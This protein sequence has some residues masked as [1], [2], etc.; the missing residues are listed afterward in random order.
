M[1]SV[2]ISDKPLYIATNLTPFLQAIMQKKSTVSVTD[3]SE[4]KLTELLEQIQS[5]HVTAAVL[6]QEPDAALNLLQQRFTHILAAGGFVYSSRQ[7]VLMIFRRGKWDLPK[8]KLDEGEDLETC[9]LREITEETGVGNLV[10]EGPLVRTYHTYEQHGQQILKESHWYM[11]KASEEAPFQPQVEE[12]IEKCE[13]VDI[14]ALEPYT[15]NTHQSILEVL[16]AGISRLG[17]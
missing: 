13:W 3:L 6:L 4:E 2:Y 7:R 17:E 15:D 8:G 9:A 11:V 5:P 1:I 14:N 10:S 12:D 16:E